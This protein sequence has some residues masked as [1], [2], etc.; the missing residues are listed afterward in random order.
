ML[1]GSIAGR[2][3]KSKRKIFDFFFLCASMRGINGARERDNT[4]GYKMFDEPILM[5]GQQM[6]VKDIISRMTRSPRIRWAFTVENVIDHSYGKHERLQYCIYDNPKGPNY[7]WE[8]ES[9]QKFIIGYEYGQIYVNNE[10]LD[11]SD[12][13]FV[14]CGS[15]IKLMNKQNDRYCDS[16]LRLVNQHALRYQIEESRRGNFMVSRGGKPL[17]MIS[18]DSEGKYHMN[19]AAKRPILPYDIPLPSTYVHLL[20]AHG[21]T[22]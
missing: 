20:L 11:E 12:P 9:D 7:F 6:T 8:P 15:A 2:I 5:N 21:T 16:V 10:L 19:V 1:C 18:P 17:Y 14:S 3:N 22:K 13:L 4:K